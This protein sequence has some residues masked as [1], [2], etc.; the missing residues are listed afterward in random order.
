MIPTMSNSVIDYGQFTL[1]P[2]SNLR[3]D[4][5]FLRGVEVGYEKGYTVGHKQGMEVAF[6]NWQVEKQ[7]LLNKIK[8]LEKNQKS[9]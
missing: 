7:E 1:Q 5:Y 3:Q 9:L 2:Q 8:E 6:N 4:P